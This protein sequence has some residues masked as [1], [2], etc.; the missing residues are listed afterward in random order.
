MLRVLV[1]RWRDW[2]TDSRER[3]VLS[4]AKTSSVTH[5]SVSRIA[6]ARL[7]QDKERLCQELR[8]AHQRTLRSALAVEELSAQQAAVRSRDRQCKALASQLALAQDQVG[9]LV[10]A[11]YQACL[12]WF[13]VDTVL[14]ALGRI[15]FHR[16]RHVSLNTDLC[17]LVCPFH[18]TGC[19]L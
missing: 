17:A 16:Q 12:G 11:A 5:R 3:P 7:C 15:V 14:S 8:Q 2:V 13:K 1:I 9:S 18:A 6:P 19:E 4:S 10:P